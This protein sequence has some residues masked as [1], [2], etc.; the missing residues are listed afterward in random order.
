M[1]L[2]CSRS[3][4]L[5]SAQIWC[6]KTTKGPVCPI[7]TGPSSYSNTLPLETVLWVICHP[8]EIV[9]QLVSLLDLGTV[10]IQVVARI[11][12]RHIL[13]GCVA[14]RYGFGIKKQ[15]RVSLFVGYVFKERL[16]PEIVPGSSIIGVILIVEAVATWSDVVALNNTE[17]LSE[18]AIAI[19]GTGLPL[20]S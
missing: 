5:S 4:A 16:V 2:L 11:D 12:I 6:G 8:C 18:G 3:L 1:S 7:T 15:G 14:E 13:E 10:T 19:K 17:M 9:Y 20:N